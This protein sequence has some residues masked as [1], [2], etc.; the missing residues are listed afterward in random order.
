VSLCE[1]ANVWVSLQE[2]VRGCVSLREFAR[3]CVSPVLV[4]VRLSESV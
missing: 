4:C 1:V 3:V 2:S